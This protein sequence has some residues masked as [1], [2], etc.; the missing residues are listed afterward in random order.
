MLKI[1]HFVKYFVRLSATQFFLFPFFF[2][3]LK[4]KMKKEKIDYSE[5]KKMVVPAATFRC[6][7]A[8]K[9]QIRSAI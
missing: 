4:F 3:F 9:C 7:I 5:K 8:K 6:A 2:F 1:V